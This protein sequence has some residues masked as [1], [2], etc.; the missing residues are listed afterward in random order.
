ML[1]WLAER[2][3]GYFHIETLARFKIPATSHQPI[4]DA[5]HPEVQRAYAFGRTLPN[6]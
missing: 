6:V 4:I 3:K 2:L 5:G 1:D